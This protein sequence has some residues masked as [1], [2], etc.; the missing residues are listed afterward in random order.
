MLHI[1]LV[2]VVECDI[3]DVSRVTMW[4]VVPEKRNLI[5]IIYIYTVKSQNTCYRF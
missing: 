1:G 5:Y 4:I 3:R 2:T